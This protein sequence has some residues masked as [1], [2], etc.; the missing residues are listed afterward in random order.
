MATLRCWTL[1]WL[2][3]WAAPAAAQSGSYLFSTI[4]GTVGNSGLADGTNF[5]ARFNSP[6]SV[7]V[8]AAGNV[9]L[10]DILNHTIRR[11][12]NSGT[13]WV[14]ETLA[15]QAGVPG[16]ADG[17][18]ADA[19]FD[20]PNGIAV[21]PGGDLFVTDH[22]NHTIRKLT[23]SG[24]N[25]I[26]TTIA[27]LAGV[28]GSTDG[29]NS[30]ARF[31][32]PTGIAVDQNEHVFVTDTANFT[33]RELIPDGTNWGVRTIAGVPLIYGFMDG[34][35]TDA[36]FDYPYGIAADNAGKVYVVDWGNHA[37]RMLQASGANWVVS[38]IAGNLG[39][40]GSDDGA[41]SVA[42]F[43]FPNG[44]CADASGNLYVADQS[45]DTI[46]KLSLSG[47]VWQVSTIGGEPLQP[48]SANGFGQ[49]S[50]FKHPWG[51]TADLNGNL[52]LTD[53]GN[54]TIREAVFMPRLQLRVVAGKPAL[55]W[56]IAA[57]NYQV[58][59]RDSLGTAAAWT[60]LTG[61]PVTNGQLLILTVNPSAPNNFYRLQKH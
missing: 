10:C 12:I 33:I 30:D 60:V 61:A 9:Y 6:G 58:Q 17:T 14:V 22:Y 4:A 34:T 48:G 11:L 49:T 47:S 28:H 24:T 31:W 3:S 29:T 32:S 27:G 50:R 36:Q 43:N 19:S 26:V 51:I 59:T 52:F 8:D 44:I 54:Q 1:L 23:R 41:G 46:R 57:A 45:N 25:W 53:Y 55:S 18:N 16:S 13:N 37:I 39:T 35:N 5:D 2:L 56:P 15:G 38:T 7:A 21:N 40:M 42:T 20:R